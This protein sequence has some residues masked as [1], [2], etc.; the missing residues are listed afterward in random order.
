MESDPNTTL[1]GMEKT[2]PSPEIVLSTQPNLSSS[3][4][5]V[6]KLGPAENPTLPSIN[7]L[8]NTNI[9]FSAE[10]LTR[11][12]SSSLKKKSIHEKLGKKRE[13]SSNSKAENFLHSRKNMKITYHPQHATKKCN[14]ICLIHI[15]SSSAD[16]ETTDSP[17]P[18]EEPS[19]LTNQNKITSAKEAIYSARDNIIEAY[20]LTSD[21]N[22]QT[23]FLDLLN[24]F[25]S[26]T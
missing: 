4:W 16:S 17:S 22:T 13:D 24:I 21:R 12:N 14:C 26:F 15:N 19:G 3:T 6:E 1:T 5:G 20:K 18:S 23:K 11:F 2:P 7:I 8:L 25:R 9:D 10:K